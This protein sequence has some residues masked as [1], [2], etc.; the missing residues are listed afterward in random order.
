MALIDIIMSI[1]IV[2]PQLLDRWLLKKKER[3][4]RERERQEKKKKKK[5]LFLSKRKGA[6]T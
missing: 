2:Q 5:K 4:K 6:L 1:V 3:K